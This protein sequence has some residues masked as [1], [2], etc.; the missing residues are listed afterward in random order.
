MAERFYIIDGHYNAYRSYYAIR[1]PNRLSS[2]DGRPTG[3]VYIFTRMLLSLLEKRQPAYVAVAFDP[4]GPTQRD[5]QFAGYKAQ[6]KPMPD[7]L[8]AQIPL[9]FEVIAG[10]RI[11][12]FQVEGFE[13]DDVI[14][15]LA[16]R[17]VER[18]VQVFMVTGD[19]DLMQLVDGER[20]LVYDTK[21]ER[22]FGPREVEEK[23]GVP[24]ALIPDLLGLAG[25]AS[26]NIPG[27]P[28]IGPKTAV[29]LLRQ[30]GSLE[31]VLEHAGSIKGKKG[32][33]L[34]DCRQQALASRALTA[35]ATD[36]PLELD[37]EALCRQPPDAGRL[38]PLFRELGFRELLATLPVEHHER[39]Y[40]IVK[41]LD[42]LE[43]LAAELKAAGAFALDFETTS[44]APVEADIV[45][46]S[47][48]YKPACAW[49][50]PLRGPEREALLPQEAV[51]RIIEPLVSDAAVTKVGQNLKYD[52]QVLHRHGIELQG[53]MFDTM[54]AAWLLAPDRH[55]YGL[56]TLALEYL[57]ER[58]IPTAELLGKG[59]EQTTMDRV[60][61]ALVAEY[62]AEDADCVWRLSRI[63]DKRLAADG[64]DSLFRE[65][66]MPLV[67][68]LAA[69]EFAGVRVDA[70]YL[71]ELG[72]H[73]Q[74][75]I[76]QKESEIRE[77][78]GC[79]FNPASPKQLA[80]VL[81]NRL[82][83]PVAKRGRAG[84]S[85]DSEVLE[86][87]A[88]K[89]PLPRLVLEYRE[90]AKLKN[91][92]V[93]TLP[94]MI[95]KSSGRIHASFNQTGTATG[96]LSSSE[97]NLQNIPVR[98]ELGRLIRRAFVP[99]AGWLFVSADYSQIELR[100]LAHFSG[101]RML[102]GAFERGGDVH[103][104]VAAEIL[105]KPPACVSAE[106]R[107]LAKA[108]NFGLIYGQQAPGLARQTGLSIAEAEEYIERYFRRYP[109][110]KQFIESIEQAA[111]QQGF[112]K[113]ILGRKRLLPDVHSDMPA[114]R[115]AARR[116]AVNTVVQG[117]AAD[118]IK[119]AMI[120]LDKSLRAR[121]MKSR[122]VIQI[123][124]EL[125]LECPP[126]EEEAAR[127]LLVE[128]M[129]GA[130]ALSAPLAVNCLRGMNWMET[131]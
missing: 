44:E 80:D 56:D 68:V 89:H 34:A 45:G 107:R 7:E 42:E 100:M 26:D 101:E 117:S 57:N 18:G 122:I 116:A 17:A 2:P 84:P 15:T 38:L 25:D 72:R 58:K 21:E 8:R 119:K 40:R 69:M 81:F 94:A 9:I 104:A 63:L 10:Y 103:R 35:L 77:A 123:H 97:P 53:P 95:S 67:S 91:T 4:K 55:A 13:A 39:D 60:S 19:K 125:L 87:L 33:R 32:Q 96:R 46:L 16:L 73:F 75:Q 83:L 124:D 111:E 114:R 86:R 41:S 23:Y 54:V 78:A 70:E 113:T 47:M 102:R 37:M 61:V 115:N 88:D 28:G 1:G 79:E 3:A 31:A 99:K 52:I 14:A 43:R 118:L 62:A 131:S 49:Y 106:E 90:L 126:D 11:P 27:V 93:D 59:K 120:V 6:R 130:M 109:A 64:L 30:F 92:Y 36:V 82:G 85:T 76:A 48:A 5:A 51:L 65:L 50:A 74:R 110:V 127:A 98:T 112:V 129:S 108:V 66:E 20:V 24:P 121:K 128:S 105:G 71:S 29:E 22:V 12:V